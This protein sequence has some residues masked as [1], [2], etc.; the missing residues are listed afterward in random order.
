M[1]SA[2]PKPQVG[3][4]LLDAG[5]SDSS[6]SRRAASTRSVLDVAGRRARRVSAAKAR[7]KWRGLMAARRG[8][9]PTERSRRGARRPRPARSP[10][11]VALGRAGPRGGAE[12]RLAAGPLQEHDQPAGDGEGDVAAEVLLDQREARS[13][14][15]VTPAE[16]QTSPSRTKIGSGS[17]VTSG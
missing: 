8:Q 9:R 11:R 16:V 17:T 5:G 2:V 3:G 14:P 15:A 1:V 7:A 4:D 13:M 6:S 10:E 12:L